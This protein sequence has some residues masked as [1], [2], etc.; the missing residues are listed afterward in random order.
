MLTLDEE[1]CCFYFPMTCGMKTVAMLYILN[2]IMMFFNAWYINPVYVLPLIPMMYGTWI[3]I[4]FLCRDTELN[5]REMAK[6]FKAVGYAVFIS[7]WISYFTPPEM[8]AMLNGKPIEEATKK[9]I[10]AYKESVTL[11][12]WHIVLTLV[13]VFFV[14]KY[15]MKQAH[16]F[17][18]L[19]D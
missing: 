10:T 1:T 11:S 7:L 14:I 15:F 18:D 12:L 8:P 9:E 19:H 6:A 5:R 3:M 16:R 2:T 13:A 4:K 17:A